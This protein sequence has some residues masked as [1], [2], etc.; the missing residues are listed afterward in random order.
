MSEDILAPESCDADIGGGSAAYSGASLAFR[1]R[2]VIEWNR[3]QQRQTFADQKRVYCK[4]M[5]GQ[6]EGSER[7]LP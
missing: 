7:S 1:D 6:G 5:Y 3:T 4:T 2:L